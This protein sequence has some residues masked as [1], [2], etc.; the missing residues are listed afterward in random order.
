M[1][2]DSNHGR[3]HM[4]RPYRKTIT[5]Q[6]LATKRQGGVGAEDQHIREGLGGGCNS[7]HLHLGGSGG[8]GR[9]PQYNSRPKSFH[10]FPLG[11][12]KTGIGGS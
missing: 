11:N 12:K 7:P 5:S 1:Q 2:Q 10:D 8:V 6:Y 3:K 9:S 4:Q